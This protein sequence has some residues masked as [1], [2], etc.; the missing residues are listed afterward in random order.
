MANHKDKAKAFVKDRE[1]LFPANLRGHLSN[2]LYTFSELGL[3]P[4]DVDSMSS[5]HALKVWALVESIRQQG[6][7]PEELRM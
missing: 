7:F 6:R 5:E 4:D 2:G 3:W 1:T